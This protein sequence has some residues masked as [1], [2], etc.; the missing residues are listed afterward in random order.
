VR[1]V[2]A[3]PRTATECLRDVA[4]PLT[5]I[6]EI[7]A[8]VVILTLFILVKRKDLRN[9]LLRL[10]GSGQL[11]VMTQAIIAPGLLNLSL[12]CF[13]IPAVWILLP[14]QLANLSLDSPSDL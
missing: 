12:T 8:I 11:S 14:C 6:L 4:G 5:G 10:A 2:A 1:I 13:F 3:P 7:A 9:R